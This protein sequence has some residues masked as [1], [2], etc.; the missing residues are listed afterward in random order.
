MP[1]LNI[2]VSPELHKHFLE[3]CEK[4][5][6]VASELIREFILRWSDAAE[7]MPRAALMP[8]TT[9]SGRT[10]S[11]ADLKPAGPKVVGFHPMTGEPIYANQGSRLKKAKA[12]K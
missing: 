3:Q 10:I 1:N 5:D 6:I 8:L 7:D 9:G 12:D 11:V 4:R 2:R